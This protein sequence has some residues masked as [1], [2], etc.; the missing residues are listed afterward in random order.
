MAMVRDA[1]TGPILS[2]ARGGSVTV[3]ADGG[4]IELVTSDGVRSRS[5]LFRAP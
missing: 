5:T 1:G 3:P 4:D 2:F